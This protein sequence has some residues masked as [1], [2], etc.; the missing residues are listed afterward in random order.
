MLKLAKEQ[1]AEHLCFIRNLS[2]TT[3][4]F[5]DSLK[6]TKVTPVYKKGFKLECAN[7][8]PITLLT[9]GSIQ[10]TIWI[11]KKFFYCTCSN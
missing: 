5:P 3:G 9:K 7:Y 6:I 2:F 11:S 10:K 8:R 1:I 4:I